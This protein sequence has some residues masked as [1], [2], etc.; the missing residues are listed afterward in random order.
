[1]CVSVLRVGLVGRV[2]ARGV[3]YVAEGHEGLV[4]L[5]REG[6]GAFTFVLGG[7]V[8]CGGGARRWQWQQ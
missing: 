8:G 3:W 2:R 7:R 6:L 4:R 5:R 1:M